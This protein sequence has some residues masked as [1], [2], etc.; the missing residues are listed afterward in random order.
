MITQFLRDLRL[1]G[2][3]EEK[4][5]DAYEAFW[6]R[7][8]ENRTAQYDAAV[9]RGLPPGQGWRAVPVPSGSGYSTW[10]IFDEDD[11]QVSLAVA[12]QRAGVGDG[13]NV[14]ARVW[15]E[16]MYDELEK[17]LAQ[18]KSSIAI[19]TLMKVGY[20]VMKRKIRKKGLKI[21]R[22]KGKGKSGRWESP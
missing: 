4:V 15:T 12:R 13:G 16:E 19:A 7:D 20:P 18:K 5:N 6:E 17:Y 9:A 1:A 2:G 22:G 14:R 3:D 10:R 8:T 11:N 21:W